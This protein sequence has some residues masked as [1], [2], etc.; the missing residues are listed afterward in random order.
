M[1]TPSDA[2]PAASF[3][4]R[5][6]LRADVT[7]GLNAS[8]K[9]LPPRWLYDRRGSKLFEQI[10]RLPEYY[11][12]R[13]ER[14]ILTQRRAPAVADLIGARTLIELGSGSSEK[15][16]L[17]LDALQER[18]PQIAYAPVDVSASALTQ[19]VTAHSSAMEAGTCTRAR[20]RP[21]CEALAQRRADSSGW[22]EVCM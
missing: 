8:P 5:A 2:A 21:Q 11:P 18:R 3:Q 15:T 4:F 20:P 13:A 10:T 16:R 6:E 9:Q 12:T 1:P 17:L 22:R 7:R 14:A 19:A